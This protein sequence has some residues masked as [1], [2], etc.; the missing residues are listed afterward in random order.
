MFI[1]V[2]FAIIL[3]AALIKGFQRGLIVAVFSLLAFVIGLAAALKLSAVV[4]GWL[5]S[6]TSISAKWLPVISFAL[7]F[8]GVVLLV[9]WG[10]KLIEKTFQ[11][12]MMGWVNRIGGMLFFTALYIVIFSIFL[13]YADK[14]KLVSPETIQASVTY[15]FIQPWGP[16]AIDN[17]GKLIPIFKDSFTELEI[18]FGRLAAKV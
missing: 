1:D 17:F 9:R 13:F 14:I 4:A 11:V 12:A 2:I 5:G 10:A 16:T 8:L 3:V 7:V 6:S 18:F 15:P